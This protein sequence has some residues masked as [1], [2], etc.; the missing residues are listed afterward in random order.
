MTFSETEHP[1][2][3]DGKF[4]EKLGAA[5]ELELDDE[6]SEARVALAEHLGIDAS[7]VTSTG[8]THYEHLPTFTAIDADGREVE[9]GVGTE[10]QAQDAAK[11]YID[12]NMWSMGSGFLAKETGLDV[13]VFLALANDSGGGEKHQENIKRMVDGLADGGSEGFVERAIEEDGRGPY[14]AQYDGEETE[15]ETDDE[16]FYLYRLN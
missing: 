9:Y 8:D 1:R 15:I 3:T 12:E 16:T 7:G 11:L 2:S 10:E 4:A 14:L 13:S 5:P 6:T